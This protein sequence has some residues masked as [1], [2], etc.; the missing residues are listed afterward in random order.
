MRSS[1]N[2][3]LKRAGI[4]CECF[5]DVDALCAAI[6][7]RR[8]GGAFPEEAVERGRSRCLAQ[9][10]ATQPPWSDLPFLVMARPGAESAEVA[11]A[12]DL[13]GNVTVIERPMRVAAL[14]RAV[15]ARV[16]RTTAPVPDP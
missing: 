3:V 1:R 7:R 4:A 14:V 6:G 2:R 12:I 13:L 11:E 9:F 16:A 10:A 8:G 15:R 5:S